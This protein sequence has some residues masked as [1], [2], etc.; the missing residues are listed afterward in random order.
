MATQY[1]R[2]VKKLRPKPKKTNDAPP[3]KVGKDYW[4]V[5]ILLL[6]IFFL[7]VGWSNFDGVNRALYISLIVSLGSTYARR[8][9][10]VTPAQEEL[11]ERVGLGAMAL[12][13]VLFIMEIYYKFIA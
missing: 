1:K 4:L 7:V 5:G 12:A 9:A 13:T 8:H 2:L 10:K 11:I 6:T 3:E